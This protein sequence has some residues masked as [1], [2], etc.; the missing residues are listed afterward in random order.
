MKTSTLGYFGLFLTLLAGILSLGNSGGAARNGNFF[1]GAPSAGGGTEGTCSTCHRGGNFGDPVLATTI[2]DADGNTFDDTFGYRPGNTYTI[3]VAVGHGDVA[4]AGYGFQSQALDATNS[5]AGTF[6]LPADSDGVQITNPGNGRSY[7]EQSRI[8]NDSTFTFEWTAPDAGTGTV[9]LYV[10]GNLVNRAAGTGG[11]NGSTA[12]LV[13]NL[14]EADLSSVRNLRTLPGRLYPNPAAEVAPVL[15]VEL[16]TAG[17]YELRLLNTLGQV[18][19]REN[20]DAPAGPMWFTLPTEGLP[21]GTYFVELRGADV[22]FSARQ[23][24][25]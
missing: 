8:S 2:T 25:R 6:A 15:E 3:T 5:R 19:A 22:R 16:P 17:A 7:A 11:D 9:D 12:P 14:L 24:L 13:L 18:M 21:P 23:V 4:P 1:T 10:T 20:H